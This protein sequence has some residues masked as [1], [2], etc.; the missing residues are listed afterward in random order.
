MDKAAFTAL[1]QNQHKFEKQAKVAL[2]FSRE[3]VK[4]QSTFSP[5]NFWSW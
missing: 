5:G 4:A 1:K 2:S 3:K